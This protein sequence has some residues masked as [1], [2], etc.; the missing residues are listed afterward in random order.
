LGRTDVAS[1][2]VDTRFSDKEK[3]DAIHALNSETRGQ[4]M[5]TNFIRI[6]NTRLINPLLNAKD[7]AKTLEEKNEI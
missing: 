5:W 1:I 3:F 4:N 6:T 7:K 2:I